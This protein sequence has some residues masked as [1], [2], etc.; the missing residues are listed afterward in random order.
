MNLSGKWAYV[1]MVF[2][3]VIVLGIQNLGQ[4]LLQWMGGLLGVGGGVVVALLAVPPFL[5]VVVTAFFVMKWNSTSWRESFWYLGFKKLNS[6][7]LAVG[8]ISLIPVAVGNGFSYLYYFQH[9]ISVEPFKNWFSLWL[10]I[11]ITSGFFEEV[12]FRGFIFQTLRK[13]S[14]FLIAAVFS[15]SLWGISHL[16]D[17]LGGF[18]QEVLLTDLATAL[19]AFFL[20]LAAVYVFERGGYVIWGWSL[21]HVLFDSMGLANIDHKGLFSLPTGLPALYQ[22]TGIALCVIITF[23]L[24]R[25]L[26]PMDKTEALNTV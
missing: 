23:P 2:L 7:Q 1:W 17:L 9:G 19:V 14:S 13:K 26:L 21:T 16:V 18:N 10:V 22:G 4:L 12:F 25:W 8:C 11:F 3:T 5:C 20:G 24:G 15:S 6:R